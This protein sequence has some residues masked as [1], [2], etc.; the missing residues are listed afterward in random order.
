M[1]SIYNSR[2]Y[3]LEILKGRGY[4]ISSYENF[5]INEVGLMLEF[6]QLDML[7]EKTSTHKKIY[8]KYYVSKVLKTQNIYDMIQDLFHL[9]NILTK[10]DDLIIITKDEPNDTLRQNVKDIWND[11]GNYISIINIKRLLFNILNHELQPKFTKL[12]AVET[13]NFK[14]KYNI[15]DDKQIPDISYFSPVSLVLGFRPGDVIHCKR[16][17]RTAIETDFYRV[18]KI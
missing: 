12:N 8:V 6:D 7:I 1:T 11:E 16:T 14:R 5:T 13:T 10:K 4:D 18:C 3:L 17:S 9:E 2:K 15:L